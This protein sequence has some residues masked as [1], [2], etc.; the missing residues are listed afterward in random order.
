MKKVIL[1]IIILLLTITCSYSQNLN[2]LYSPWGFSAPF[3]KSGEFVLSTRGYYNW[4]DSETFYEDEPD[5]YS[6]NE[7]TNFYVYARGLLA[8]TDKFL[9]NAT[10]YF[11]PK[12]ETSRYY[13]GNTTYDQESWY[14]RNA[15]FYPYFTL[16]FRPVKNLEFS[17]TFSHR[18]S[19]QRYDRIYN[20]EE[21][22]YSDNT[23]TYNY[24]NVGVNYF[25][26]LWGK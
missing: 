14:T 7:S 3:L 9:I 18:S 15:Y 21:T 2:N 24:L 23:Y 22:P 19:D 26:K 12:E 1:F 17:G 5:R 11:Y 10:L 6:R 13:S 16:I 20:D 8:V 4:N 25:G